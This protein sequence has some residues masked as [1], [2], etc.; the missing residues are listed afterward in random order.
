MCWTEGRWHRHFKSIRARTMVRIA[1]V[2]T[3]LG[4]H[5]L[6]VLEEGHA[7]G[8]FPIKSTIQLAGIPGS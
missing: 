5:L 7:L 6:K 3:A 2:P 8:I 1:L 4:L